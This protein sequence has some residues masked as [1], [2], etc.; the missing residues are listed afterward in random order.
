MPISKEQARNLGRAFLD[1]A[2]ALGEYRFENWNDLAAADRRSIEDEE[3]DLLTYSSSLT[4]KA[5]GVVL[6][7]LKGDLAA[8]AEGAARATTAIG[9]VKDVK[10]ALKVA[11]AFVALGGA[12]VSGNAVAIVTAA[13]GALEAAKEAA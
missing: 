10:V 11:T 6:D 13:A 3:W 2:H 1:V 7:D 4:T 12:I 9:T 5:V 8:I